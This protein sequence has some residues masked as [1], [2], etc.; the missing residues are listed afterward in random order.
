MPRLHRLFL[1]T[2]LALIPAAAQ[3]IV[4]ITPNTAV[5]GSGELPLT[6]DGS[7]NSF[8]NGATV[9]FG[10]TPL[11]TN[12]V[13]GNRLTATIPGAL[14]TTAGTVFVTVENPG[15]T[16]SNALTFTI[17]AAS[18][19]PPT[20]TSLSP[21]SVAAGAAGFTLTV[22]GADFVSGSTVQ[23]GVTALTTTFVGATQLTAAVPANLVASQG[24][25]NITVVNPGPVTSAAAVFTITAPPAPTISSLSPSSGVAGGPAFTLAVTG[26]NF[27]SGSTVQWGGTALTT[28]FVSA[29]QLTAAVPANLIASPGPVNVTVVN[30]GPVTSAAAVFTVTAPPPVISSLTPASVSAGAPAFD[31]AVSGS[32]FVS[33]STVQWG[34]AALATTFVSATQLTAAVPANLVAAPGSVN[35]TVVNPGPVPSAPFSFTIGAAPAPTISSLSPSSAVA[36]GA[37]FTLTVTGTNFVSGSTVQWGGAALTTTFG[38]ATQLTAAVPANLVA[39]PGSVNITVVNPGPVTSAAAVFTV[40]APPPV[41]SSLTPAS[42]SAGAPAFD[43]AVSG[44]GFVSGSTVQWGSTALTTTFVSATQ[45]TAAVPANLVAA[46]GSVNVT[47][48]NPGPV[49]SAPFSFTIGAAPAPAISSLSPSS[50]VAG[51]PAFT[52]TV[53]GSNFVSGSTVQWGGTAL[54]TTFVS[55]TQLTAAVPA[56]LVAAAGSVNVTVV[57]PGP[58]TSAPAVFTIGSAPAISSLSPS[59]VSAGAPGFNLT[60]SGSG[61]VA[62]STVQ[63]AGTAL[64]T[65][66]VSATQLTAAVPANLLTAPASVNITVVNPG[67]VTSAPA[68]FTV[69][70]GPTI[71]SITPNATTA[72]APSF[73]LTVNGSGFNASS[74]IRLA[75]QALST[76]FVSANQL[77]AVITPSLIPSAGTVSITV[78]NAG[79]VVSNAVSL[80]INAQTQIVTATLAPGLIGTAYTQAL[81]VAGGTA[82]YQFVLASGNFPPGLSLD[83]NTGA[84]TGTPVEAGSYNFTIQ[85]TDAAGFVATRQ[86]NLV[87]ARSVSISTDANLPTGAVGLAYSVQLNATGGVPPYS[88]WRVTTGSLPP[89]ISL[90][91]STGQLTGTPTTTGS[92]AFLVEVRDSSGQTA[93]KGFT[94]VINAGVSITSTAQPPTAIV[95]TPFQ[96]A[97]TAAGGTQPYTWSIL[98]GSL[99]P[100]L[101]L[102]PA[103]G[104]IAGTPTTVGT[105]GVTIEVK[106]APGQTARAPFTFEV[107]TG[108][109]ITNPAALPAATARVAYTTVFQAAGGTGP[110]S[111][112]RIVTGSVPAPLI[113]N[114]STGELA[115]TP[116]TPGDYAFTIAVNDSATRTVSKA[117]TLTVL[118]PGLAI[119][120]AATLPP[121][122]FG[123]AYSFT[124]QADGGTVPYRWSLASG[125][126]PAGL[127]LANT[128]VISGT[129]TAIGS[130]AFT[131]SVLDSASRSSS[132][133]FTL[134]VGSPALPAFNLS[135]PADTVD[136]ATQPRLAL[137]LASAYPVALSGSVAIT[138]TADTVNAPSGASDDPALQFANGTRSIRFT[139]PAGSTSAAFEGTPAFQTGTLAGTIILTTSF[140]T[141]STPVPGVTA[142]RTIRILRA[143]P[144]VRAAT[145]TRTASGFDVTVTG[146]STPRE[147]TQALFRFTPASGANLQTTELTLPLTA[148]ATTW[149]TSDQSRAFGGQFTYRQSFT[150]TGESN[151]VASI[152]VTLSNSTGASQAAS[153][154]VP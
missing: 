100:G 104:T 130:S 32:G 60:V 134:A 56:N 91:A 96:F 77:S 61:F 147:V 84:I 98:T 45:L 136:A 44:S 14:L 150:L 142:P 95:G 153:A 129:P 8:A 126:L 15:P 40:T 78:A 69:G 5:A 123:T 103:N 127:T 18:T 57:N 21:S 70:A 24:Q 36:G 6:V 46:P 88:N 53:S 67:P 89:G 51:A 7:G 23:W 74:A 107:V 90:N 72:G 27:V 112:W 133:D 76:T 20:I 92:F 139:I 152:S 19:P 43:L 122:T 97:L 58:V 115:G 87:I 119:T 146:Y 9:K 148:P 54:A 110:Y 114:S 29:T 55:A 151:A 117:F 25:V 154:N 80:L 47:V 93:T 42:V 137:D 73:T 62:A 109:S 149:F 75:G 85:V 22:T 39:A 71:T 50:A 135:G 94:L 144:T 131:I 59:S 35:I 101:T 26:T 86:F 34:G 68:V 48:V 64:T 65:T 11:V 118:P 31:L 79:P 17:T 128:G 132:R 124:L 2:I 106:D 41:I 125:N 37:A 99:P 33:G 12:R 28:T 81:S 141:G 111:N 30:P 38:S 10:A 102:N 1:A 52:L 113:L 82:P 16:V 49:T 143:A 116:A 121:A 120:S 4:S 138:F 108:L 105:F 145:V 83:P 140:A 3:T 13:N 66:F 63:W